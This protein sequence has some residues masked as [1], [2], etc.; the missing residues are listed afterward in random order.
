DAYDLT[1]GLAARYRIFQRLTASA[2][3]GLGAQ[4]VRVAVDPHTGPD[5][6]GDEPPYDHAWGALATAGVALDVFALAHPPFGLGFR[7][8]AGYVAARPLAVNLH[9]DPPDGA[10]TLAMTSAALGHL[11]LS[12][13]SV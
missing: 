5:A 1:A 11:D 13:P 4:R 9:V 8:A 7:F 6:G 3:V 10:I 12:G 2:R